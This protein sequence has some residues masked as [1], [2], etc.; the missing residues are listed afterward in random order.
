MLANLTKRHFLVFFKNKM[1]VFYTLMVPLILLLVYVFFLRELELTLTRD[2][3]KEVLI[4][5]INDPVYNSLLSNVNCL[6]DSWM[7]SGIIA[8]STITVSIQTNNIIVND[9]ENGV[10]RDFAS[11]PVNKSVLIASYFIFN[12]IVTLLIC[13]IVLLICFAYILSKGEWVLTFADVMIII[14]ILAFDT[15]SSTFLTLFICSFIKKES[16]LASVIAIFSAGAGFVIGA[17]IPASMLPSWVQ[18]SCFISYFPGTYQCSLMRYAFLDTPF[19]NLQQTITNLANQGLVDTTSVSSLLTEVEK[20]YGYNVYF[21]NNTIIGPGWQAIISL[22][23]DAI[24]LVLNIFT[25]SKLTN[26]ATNKVRIF[27]RKTNKKIERDFKFEKI[28]NKENNSQGN[29][30]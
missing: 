2:T 8:L 18:D 4:N 15:I 11:S 21:Y 6:V 14:G 10:N 24:L 19:L 20:N 27:V 22:I 29:D 26:I 23:F 1:R 17:Y 25:S 13:S 7:L 12:Y 28:K 9:K 5:D 3:L 30:E 16:T